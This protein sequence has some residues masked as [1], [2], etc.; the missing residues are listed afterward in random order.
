MQGVV[1][2]V[3]HGLVGALGWVEGL[4]LGHM[5][6]VDAFAMRVDRGLFD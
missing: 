5:E 6:F 2:A 4:V 3:V 1:N